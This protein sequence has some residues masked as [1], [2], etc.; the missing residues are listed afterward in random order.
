[1]G[2]DM[3]LKT[4]SKKACK[5]ANRATSNDPWRIADGIAIY[6]RKANAIHQWFVEHVQYGEDDCK[7]YPVSVEQLIE[8]RD[9]CKKVLRDTSLAEVLLPTCEGFFF[10]GTEY[11]EYY[12]GQLEITVDGIGAIL[13][14]IERYKQ[15]SV[16]NFVWDEWREKGDKD[17]WS[18]RFY[19]K[20]SW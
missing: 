11:D 18:V 17:E 7:I 13:K 19:Y 9:A 5:A 10:G 15:H 16:G 1:M 14:N 8:L 6:W 20:S 4:N 3:Y 12:F 2:L